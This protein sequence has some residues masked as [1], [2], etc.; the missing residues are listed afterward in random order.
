MKVLKMFK[1]IDKDV[2]LIKDRSNGIK[3]KISLEELNKLLKIDEEGNIEKYNENFV[4]EPLDGN[5]DDVLNNFSEYADV[6][7]KDFIEEYI[8]NN[9]I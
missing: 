6:T 3:K 8:Y 4:L 7:T 2:F 5:L 9:E 1:E